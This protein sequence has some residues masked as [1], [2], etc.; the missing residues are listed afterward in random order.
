MAFEYEQQILA[1]SLQRAK[2]EAVAAA[3]REQEAVRTRWVTGSL[4]AGLAIAVAIIVFAINR[5][6]VIRKQKAT[7][8]LQKAQIQRDYT[9]LK[10]FTEN[11]AHEMQTPMAVIRSKLEALLQRPD[12]TEAHIHDVMAVYGASGRL[13]HLN[14]SLLLLSRIENN[15]YSVDQQVNYSNVVNQHLDWFRELME[16]QEL[17]VTTNITDDLSATTLT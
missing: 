17:K 16:H 7:I 15:Q 1:D 9:H 5:A 6:R 8:E 13:T 10:D 2:D 14:K 11:A 3:Q 12:L 4:I